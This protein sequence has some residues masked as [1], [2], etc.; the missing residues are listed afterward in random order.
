[1][2]AKSSPLEHRA[3]KGAS[4][5]PL[6]RMMRIHARLKAED[7]P[8]C[9]K[10]GEDLEVSSKTIQRDIDF[11]RDRLGLPIEYDALRFGF[12][13]TEEVTSFPSIEVSEGEV[14]ALFV[15]QKALAQ[16]RGTPFERPLRSAF[17][18]IA[19][20]LKDRVSFSWS[21]MEEAISFHS[22]G[23]SVA[24]LALFER[25]SQAVLKSVELEFEYRKLNSKDYGPRRVRPFHIACLENQWYLFAEDLERKKLRTFALPRMQ[26][27][28]LT[29][30]R[31]RR[32]ARFSIR[33]LLSGSF[34][35]FSGG[36]KERIRLEFDPFAARLVSER[37]W[38]ESQRISEAQDGSIVLQLELGGLEEIQRWVL[39]W[40][41][42]VRVLEPLQLRERIGEAAEAISQLYRTP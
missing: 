19:D 16:Y 15:A 8:N 20:S 31:F 40:G 4:R 12:Y 33:K 3:K 25:V 38:H 13:Y 5:P 32:P 23:A 22:A 37:T 35:V 21:D 2:P 9:R 36:R 27:V 34:G 42:H 10:I 24:D 18:K 29:T 11:M 26:Q 39:S 28:R 17:R 6:E 30:K 41:S 7:Y 1:M 14:A